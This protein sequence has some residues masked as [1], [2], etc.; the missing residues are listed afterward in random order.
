MEDK[1][2]EFVKVSER[3]IHFRFYTNILIMEKKRQYEITNGVYSIETIIIEKIILT[4]ILQ[5]T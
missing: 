5:S 4:E 2:R 3:I 1:I